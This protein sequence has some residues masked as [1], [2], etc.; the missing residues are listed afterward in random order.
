M[1]QYLFFQ[2]FHCSGRAVDSPRMT[3]GQDGTIDI[4]QRFNRGHY[5]IA[6]H[7][8]LSTEG[9]ARVGVEDSN[10]NR[11]INTTNS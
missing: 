6:Q 1:S 4:D 9:L 10:D 2:R 11:H 5:V 3:W 7:E 8:A